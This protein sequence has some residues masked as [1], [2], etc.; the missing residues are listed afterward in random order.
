[1]WIKKL[2]H[3]P[4]NKAQIWKTDETGD[5]HTTSEHVTTS[6]AAFVS[7][8]KV[9][10]DG[11]SNTSFKLCLQKKKQ[12]TKNELQKPSHSKC[13]WYSFKQ[14]LRMSKPKV[15]TTSENN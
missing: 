8:I 5:M 1:M 12:W 11:A 6:C 4:K 14:M 2:N 13:W 3:D 7:F 10:T 15:E 9:I